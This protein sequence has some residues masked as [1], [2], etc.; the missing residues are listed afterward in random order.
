MVHSEVVRKVNEESKV[1]S[2]NDIRVPEF[3]EALAELDLLHTVFYLI[4]NVAG[5]D[6]QS[7]DSQK[8][9]LN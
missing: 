3:N 5:L 9:I 4:S 7:E 1:S 6:P 2:R 8:T